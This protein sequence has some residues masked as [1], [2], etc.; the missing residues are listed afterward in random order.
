[1]SSVAPVGGATKVGLAENVTVAFSEAADPATISTP[2][3]G[4]VKRK[5]GGGG[6]ALMSCGAAVTTG[7][8]DLT[9]NGLVFAKT[10]S[11]KTR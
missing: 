9:G 2:A 11:F 1:M 8:K 7:A 4:L 10:W 5:N 3:V 6:H